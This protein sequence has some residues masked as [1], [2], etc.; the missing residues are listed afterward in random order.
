METASSQTWSR[1]SFVFV[2]ALLTACATSTA[3][4]SNPW[5]TVSRSYA[6]GS[7]EERTRLNAF[8][9]PCINHARETFPQA[10]SRFEAGLPAGTD[11]VVVA[12]RRSG[13]T[14][15]VLVNDIDGSQIDG[16]IANPKVHVDGRDFVHGDKY[17]L[18]TTDIAD[19]LITYPDRPEE[20]NL[21][22]KY[23]LLRQDGLVSG[24]CDP[25][26]SEFRHFRFFEMEYSFVP[27]D[28]KGW[29]VSSEANGHDFLMQQGRNDPNKFNAVYAM[30]FDVPV[31]K[32]DQ[33]M[34]DSISRSKS[35]DFGNP[36]RYTLLKHD[37]AADTAHEAR[38]VRS[39][40]VVED[41]QAL[42][43]EETRERGLMI[44]EHLQLACIHPRIDT[45]AVAITYLHTHPPGRRDPEV[46]EKADTV[47]KSLAFKT[48]N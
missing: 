48:R 35:D 15:Y 9:Q 38:C 22:G 12:R 13:S 33:E 29:E 40:Q 20:G 36:K 11:F 24:P 7:A 2:T 31:F 44:V 16:R 5:Q 42:L 34:I 32:T 47:F 46:D 19:W 1:I 27:P 39:I 10:V 8:L 23:L 26:G 21:L 17:A 3:P 25:Y 14:F 37:V 18:A 45:M 4:P 28:P 30:H 6:P 43:S 41:K